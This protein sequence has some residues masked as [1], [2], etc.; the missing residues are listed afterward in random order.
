M[1]SYN[2]LLNR[3]GNQKLGELL[4]RQNSLVS[5]IPL[6]IFYTSGTTDKPE[7][8]TLT[9]FQM[10]NSVAVVNE[11]LGK[12]FTQLCVPIPTFHIFAEIIGTFHIAVENKNCLV[13]P[14]ML[15]DTL[16]TMKFIQ[17]EKCTA[18]I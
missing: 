2:D 1:H 8:A 16:K 5:D 13:Y 10:L 12:Y 14:A 17:N 11:H 9:N 7:A 6:A 4:E 18:L 3:G 15:Q